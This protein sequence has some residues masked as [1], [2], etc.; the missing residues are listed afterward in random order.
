MHILANTHTNTCTMLGGD[1]FAQMVKDIHT[2]MLVNYYEDF[3]AFCFN[4]NAY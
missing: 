1:S 3:F 2:K 4:E